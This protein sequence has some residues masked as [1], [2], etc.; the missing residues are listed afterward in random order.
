MAVHDGDVANP[1][2]EPT[3]VVMLG[4]GLVGLAGAE[5]RRRWKKRVVRNC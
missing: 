5:V 3:A 2:P 1:V 4:I